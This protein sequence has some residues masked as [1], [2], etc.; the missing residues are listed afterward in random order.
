VDTPSSPRPI[1]RR[2]GRHSS[3]V[4]QTCKD[5]SS[6]QRVLE[7]LKSCV[8]GRV[9][10]GSHVPQYSKNFHHSESSEVLAYVRDDHPAWG[11]M[12]QARGF[13]GFKLVHQLLTID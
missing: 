2:L 5:P 7:L 13:A 8:S 9:G 1:S 4:L 10:F 12:Y 3:L 6:L 11:Y